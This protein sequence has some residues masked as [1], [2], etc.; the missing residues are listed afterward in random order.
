MNGRMQTRPHST[1]WGVVALQ[2]AVEASTAKRQS[3]GL[4]CF[5]FMVV[6]VIWGPTDSDQ[7]PNTVAHRISNLVHVSHANTIAWR[8]GVF[9]YFYLKSKIHDLVMKNRKFT[10]RKSLSCRKN[11]VR[12]SFPNGI[13]SYG[14]GCLFR[15]LRMSSLVIG[16]LTSGHSVKLTSAWLVT[17]NRCD[18]FDLETKFIFCMEYKSHSDLV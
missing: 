14:C 1:H 2:N 17:E 3:G 18:K 11:S 16:T 9:T 6:S 13:R 5:C 4:F 10:Y 12:F 8:V 7:L 15:I